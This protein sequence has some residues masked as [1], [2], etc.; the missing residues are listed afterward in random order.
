MEDCQEEI[1]KLLQF[2]VVNAQGGEEVDRE[3]ALWEA[4][5]GKVHE[6][7]ME[8]WRGMMKRMGGNA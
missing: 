5:L 6:G 1:R 4:E 3:V 8:N 7:N 2:D